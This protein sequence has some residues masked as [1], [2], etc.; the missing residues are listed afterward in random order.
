MHN[1]KGIALL[2]ILSVISIF[3][4]LMTEIVTLTRI[5]SISS[6]ARANDIQAYYS[7]L[8]GYKMATLFIIAHG[9]LANNETVK[10]FV[11]KQTTLLDL[12]WTLGF[13][14]PLPIQAEEI[15]THEPSKLK[16]NIQVTNE[17]L[18]SKINLNLL[19]SEKQ[20]ERDV[21]KH[22]LFNLF[23]FE[24]KNNPEFYNKYKNN[25]Q[26]I[27]ENIE[28]WVDVDS[29]TLQGGPEEKLYE[30]LPY[31]AKNDFF[32]TVEELHLIPSMNDEIF[33]FYKPTI[34]VYGSS[35]INVNYAPH[36]IMKAISTQ[37]DDEDVEKIIA[38]RPFLDE[39]AFDE[40][41]INTLLKIPSYN[42]NPKVPLS[43]GGNIFKVESKAQVGGAH[44]TMTIVMDREVLSTDHKPYI[45]YF[46][47]N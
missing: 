3:M 42:S 34:T 28:D 47:I 8:S 43:T 38:A 24:Q 2:L 9:K 14:Y 36:K 7:A 15:E 30:K 31:T 41:V 1:Q 20:E 37:F 6:R 11:G 21:I 46:E 13:T 19:G 10:Q 12:I 45:Y 26:N 17:L 25:I 44:K 5:H 18:S 32:D 16:G 33:N 40:F 39:K 22:L 27:I 23:Q 35:A 29:R 4:L